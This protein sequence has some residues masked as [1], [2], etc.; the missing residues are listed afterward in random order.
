MV[1]M[2]GKGSAGEVATRVPKT[3][4]ELEAEG[5][6]AGLKNIH[7]KGPILKIL[8]QAGLDIEDFD[9]QII[10]DLPTWTQIQNLYGTGPH[11][12]GLEKCHEFVAATDPTVRFFGV[13]GTFN[14]GTNL[15]AELLTKNCQITERMVV[16]G[17]QSRGVRWQVRS[18]V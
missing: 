14:S 17:N 10:D 5:I 1:M 16:Y 4:A 3:P 18:E 6:A 11:L 9:Q 12:I 2:A 15:V 13:A 7:D 8:H